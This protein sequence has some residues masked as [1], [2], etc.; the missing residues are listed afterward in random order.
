MIGL[1]VLNIILGNVIFR[2]FWRIRG[3]IAG[4]PIRVY[5]LVAVF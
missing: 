3:E 5:D 1:A 4:Y 2:L